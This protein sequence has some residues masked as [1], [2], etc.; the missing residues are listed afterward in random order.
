MHPLSP[1]VRGW[2]LLLALFIGVGRDWFEAV[3]TGRPMEG[4]W[5]DVPLPALTVGGAAVIA[6]IIAGFALSWWSTRYQFGEKTVRLRT[7]ILFRQH[8]EARIDRVQAVDVVQPLLARVFGLAEL[9]FEVA[10]AGESALRLAFLPLAE[11]HELRAKVMAAA[12]AA[13]AREHASAPSVPPGAPPALA[14]APLAPGPALPAAPPPH[15]TLL[16]A[17]PLGRVLAAAALSPEFVGMVLALVAAGIFDAASGARVL[18]V[19]LIPMLLAFAAS[20]WGRI[21]RSWRF[22]VLATDQGLRLRYGLLETR[23]Q[24]VAEGRVQA[25]GIRQPLLWRPFGWWSVKVNVAGYGRASEE[26]RGKSLVLPVGT[27]EDV[28]RLLG[29][30]L[31]DPGLPDPGA[32]APG[33]GPETSAAAPARAVFEAGLTGSG[34]GHGFLH[35]PSPARWLDPLTWRRNAYLATR[36]A[37]L[38][39]TGRFARALVIVPH[40]RTQSIALTQGP[41]ERRL[42]LASVE[43]HS[44]SSVFPAA[45]PH[46]SSHD[47]EALFAAQAVRAARARGRAS[48]GG[49][50]RAVPAE[51]RPPSSALSTPSA[52]PAPSA[53]SAPS[54][55]PAP[56]ETR[57]GEN[58]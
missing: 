5:S 58:R 18:A 39:R 49:S 24:T 38:A 7:G 6:L 20:V 52:P 37:L 47:A 25:I 21:N 12:A 4:W 31:P 57:E 30:I 35:A 1:W 48:A 32:A 23:T 3:L 15:E 19:A 53:P 45:V 43:L 46:L 10:D 9:R 8:R 36:T 2:I 28:F 56:P 55:P 42:G 51:E 17:V 29:A 40:E 50:P 13:R 41:L 33:A 44:T 14:P 16:A 26:E 11:A 34:T 22:R 54:A 27:V